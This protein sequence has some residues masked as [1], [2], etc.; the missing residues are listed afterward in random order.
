VEELFKVICSIAT[1]KP[2]SA[3]DPADDQSVD[4]AQA[5]VGTGGGADT[6]RSYGAKGEN[7]KLADIQSKVK[8]TFLSK[9]EFGA[10]L[11]DDLDEKCLMRVQNYRE[12]PASNEMTG[13]TD[14]GPIDN[15]MTTSQVNL[16]ENSQHRPTTGMTQHSGS[17][18]ESNAESEFFAMELIP[19]QSILVPSVSINNGV[20]MIVQHTEACY[21]VRKHIIEVA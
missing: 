17:I 3:S 12:E 15:S 21:F 2:T 7:E 5:S 1:R 6:S 18:G 19:K 14:V 16:R 10:Q 8:L 13:H 20:N 4:N 11:Y 9:E